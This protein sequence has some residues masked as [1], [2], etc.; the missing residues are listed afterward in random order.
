MA[1][2]DTIDG[3]SLKRVEISDLVYLY[4]YYSEVNS[5]NRTYANINSQK[6]GC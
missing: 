1:S 4:K 3:M 6:M 5:L 2:Q